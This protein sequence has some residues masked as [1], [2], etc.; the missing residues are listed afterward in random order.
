M[1]KPPKSFHEQ[2][3]CHNCTKCLRWGDGETEYFACNAKDDRPLF[4]DCSGDEVLYKEA[5][6]VR[7]L[8]IKQRKEANNIWCD[9]YYAHLVNP[10]GICDEYKN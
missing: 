7:D 8:P 9:W 4:A 2:P 10:W 1:S 3:G 6:Q 5:E